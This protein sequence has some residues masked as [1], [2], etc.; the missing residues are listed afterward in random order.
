MKSRIHITQIVP[1]DIVH[2]FSGYQEVIDTLL[3]GAQE[4]GYE[5][6]FAFN[7]LRPDA[8]NIVFSAHN[9]SIDL[10]KSFPPDT[11]IYNLEQSWGMF[12]PL[13]G[14]D[15]MPHLR[16]S[17]DFMRKTFMFWDYST[18]N[19]EAMLT[20]DS[21]M[22]ARHVPIGYAPVLQRIP[23]PAEQDIDVLIYGYP[24]DYRL[25]LFEKLCAQW[26]KC[27]FACGVYGAMRDDLIGRSKIVLNITGGHDES[28]WPIVRGSYLLANR[29]LVVADLQPLLHIEG[30][31]MHAVKF[32]TTEQLPWICHE[33]INND[34]ARADA[35][36]QG[37]QVMARRDIRDI[38][39]M[40]LA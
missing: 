1:T 29:K 36:E 40:A 22:P 30:D 21:P 24:H 12:L 7:A 33:W 17:Y 19:V 27:V 14:E 6:T 5:A 26:K 9:A 38:L 8:R 13:Q 34:A 16:E 37:F 18:K 10:L 23:K 35:E 25:N 11:I 2:V 39:T 15:T 4:L 28:I 3:W 31:M 32:A 20:V